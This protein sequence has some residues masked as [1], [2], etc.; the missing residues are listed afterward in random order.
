MT[1]NSSAPVDNIT[2]SESFL[3]KAVIAVV[4]IVVITLGVMANQTNEERFRQEVER[5]VLNEL[6]VKRVGLESNVLQNIALVKGLVAHVSSNPG[7]TQEEYTSYAKYL[8]QGHHQLRNLGGAP[9]MVIRFVYPLEGNEKA[10]GLDYKKNPN[11]WEAVQQAIGARDVVV[12]GPV[13]LVQGG[14][15][16]IGRMPVYV[17]QGEESVQLLWGL[18]SAVIDVEA[19]YFQSG[20]LDANSNIEI[21]IRGKDAKGEQG[22]V[23]FGDSA[24]FS[25]EPLIK[26]IKLPYGSWQIAAIPK[27]GWPTRA[28]NAPLIWLV[29]GLFLLAFLVPVYFVMKSNRRRWEQ[30][31]RLR[32]LFE[33]SPFGIALN[34]FDTGEFIELNEAM[35][36]PTGYSREEFLRLSYWDLTPKDFETNEQEQLELLKTT[37]RYGPYR[38]EYI[39]KSGERYPVLLNGLL[40]KDSSGKRYIWSIVEDITER[41]AASKERE[42]LSQIASQTDNG[43]VVS[44]AEGRIEW[45]NQAYTLMSGYHLDEIQGRLPSDFLHGEGTDQQAADLIANS[46]RQRKAFTVE[47]LNYKK[48]GEAYWVEMRCN[49]LHDEKGRLQGFMSLEIDISKQKRTEMIMESQREMLQSMSRQGRI[50]AWEYDI[51]K[52]KVYW[53][54]MTKEIHQ[55]HEEFEPNLETA[56]HFF[57]EGRDRTRIIELVEQCQKTGEPWSEELTIVTA[58]GRTIWVHTSGQAEMFEGQCVRLYGSYQDIDSKKRAQLALIEAKEQ[59][60]AAVQVKSEFLAT[61]SH[62]IRTP[63]NGVL[64]MLGLLLNTSLDDN[65]RRRAEIAKSSAESLLTIINDILDF[66]K[67]DAG[68]LDFEDIEFDLHSMLNEFTESFA[69]KA[70]EKGLELVLDYTQIL[71]PHVNGDPGRIRQILTNLVS[72]ALKFTEQGEIV[73][74]GWQELEPGNKVRLFFSV[75]DTGIGIPKDKAMGLFDSFTQVDASTTRKYGGTGLGLAIAKQL[76]HLMNGEISVESTKGKGSCFEFNVVLDK[77]AS[78]KPVVHMMPLDNINVLVVDDNATNR[79][80]LCDQLNLW[81]AN[82]IAASGGQQ[83]LNLLE[84]KFYQQQANPFDVVILDYQ[85]PE[86]HGGQ[87][88]LKLKGDPRFADMH[89]ILMTSVTSKGDAQY[90]ADLGFSAYFPKPATNADLHA[91]LSVVLE[92]GEALAQAQPLVT[93]HYLHSLDVNDDELTV[94]GAQSFSFS[95]SHRILLVEDNRVNQLVANDMLEEMGVSSVAT[96]NGLEAIEELKKSLDDAPY[97]AILMDCQMPEMDGYEATRAIRQGQAGERYKEI[98]IIAL[99]ANAMAGDE[100]KCREAGMNDYLAKPISPER[101]SAK[102]KRWLSSVNPS[103]IVADFF[104]VTAVDVPVWDYEESLNRFAGKKD[105]LLKVLHVFLDDMASNTKALQKSLFDNRLEETCQIIH[106]LKGAA[107]N[108]GANAYAQVLAEM[109]ALAS[110]HQGLELREKWPDLLAAQQELKQVLEVHL[111]TADGEQAG[112]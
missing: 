99:T 88:A 90:F 15:G 105:K 7:I 70:E 94:A 28:D 86:M 10:I 95:K 47:I 26:T 24:V 35:Y 71:E 53:S 21:A 2:T 56:M 66:S 97:H 108:V 34:D 78:H 44:D 4:L 57:K 3:F 67:V 64:G 82:I 49:P 106:T 12:A 18:V 75:S 62:E 39:K 55:V 52:G 37:G 42:K 91:A 8:L 41:V 65:Q 69:F 17:D 92:G 85:M 103:D 61:M 111:A 72:N 9:D 6:S 104:Q 1:N 50:G 73:I 112:D 30:E 31:K 14:Q 33:L 59:A 38:K 27:G 96:G 45:V 19:L 43:V 46:M 48:S 107:G 20:L 5:D 93:S 51:H 102:L 23:F 74:R 11:Q 22:D 25:Q 77:G 40:V 84:E 100:E 63:M 29:S 89:L 68:K 76:C 60:E 83:A 16:F 101:L 80:V 32:G 110:A 36:A 79:Q 87:L 13:D 109:Y 98:P 54:E 81:G 58:N